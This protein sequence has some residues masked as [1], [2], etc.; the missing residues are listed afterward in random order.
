[1]WLQ[2][3][4]LHS[5]RC[6]CSNASSFL[7]CSLSKLGG[8]T[9]VGAAPDAAAAAAPKAPH[10]TSESRPTALAIAPHPLFSTHHYTQSVVPHKACRFTAHPHLLISAPDL[11]AGAA[12]LEFI[13]AQDTLAEGH[14]SQAE[15][16]VLLL[17]QG[18]VATGTVGSRLGVFLQ[19][20]VRQ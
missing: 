10:R 12:A 8:C 7:T 14:T 2:W 18:A 1:M 5:S 3:T 17:G 15:A 9:H 6:W 11:Q 4:A 20:L 19:L 13:L 16:R